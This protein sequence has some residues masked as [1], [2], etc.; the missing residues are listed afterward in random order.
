MKRDRHDGLVVVWLWILLGKRI[1]GEK[2]KNKNRR[3]ESING[4]C[5]KIKDRIEPVSLWQ[6]EFMSNMGKRIG[7]I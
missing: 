2:K 7:G 4:V 3:R 1:V 6:S 5:K